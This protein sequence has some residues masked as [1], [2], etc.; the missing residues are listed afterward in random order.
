M[1]VQMPV[2]SEITVVFKDGRKLVI[3]EDYVIAFEKG[4][5]KPRNLIYDSLFMDDYEPK[6]G[7][8][9]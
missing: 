2:F 5:T 9:R 6:K 3:G 7:K 8:K 4:S 1:V